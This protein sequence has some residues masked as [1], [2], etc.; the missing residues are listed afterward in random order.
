ME[1]GG[2]KKNFFGHVFDFEDDSKNE[3]LNLAQY[4]VLAAVFVTVLNKVFESYMPDPEKDKSAAALALETGLQL[5]LLFVGLVLIHRTIE[6]IPTFSGTRYGSYNIIPTV[7]PMLVVLLS[8][9]SGVGRK[10]SML[11]DKFDGVKAPAKQPPVQQQMQQPGPPALSLLPQ[12]MNTLSNPMGQSAIPGPP[13]DPDF[14]SSFEPM[15]ANSGGV[16]F[17]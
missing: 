1:D 15:A 12:G 17:F 6:Y 16:N 13:S 8:L 5:V 3:L 9:N 4:S 14:S 10:V 7:L 11:V 2:K